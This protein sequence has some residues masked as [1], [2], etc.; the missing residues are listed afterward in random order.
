M[1]VFHFPMSSN[2]KKC[3]YFRRNI[4]KLN[5]QTNIIFIHPGINAIGFLYPLESQI[6]C[7]SYWCLKRNHFNTIIVYRLKVVFVCGTFCISPAIHPFKYHYHAT[8]VRSYPI[9]ILFQ[10]VLDQSHQET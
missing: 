10:M 9:Q 4:H 5:Q 3:A 8:V 2:N 7:R 6:M 1:W